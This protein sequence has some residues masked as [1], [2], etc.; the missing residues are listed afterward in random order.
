MPELGRVLEGQKLT[1]RTGNGEVGRQTIKIVILAG[2]VLAGALLWRKTKRIRK[3]RKRGG[4]KRER[5]GRDEEEKVV[6][7]EEE[8]EEKRMKYT[9]ESFRVSRSSSTAVFGRRFCIRRWMIMIPF[10]LEENL[11][12]DSSPE[13]RHGI[14]A[15]TATRNQR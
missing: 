4:E 2:W 1:R 5:E 11:V 7:D 10:G 6:G 13:V 15:V 14:T 3:R 9:Y 8:M 12:V